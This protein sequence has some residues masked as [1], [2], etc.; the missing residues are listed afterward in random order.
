MKRLILIFVALLPYF[1]VAQSQS[2]KIVEKA[3]TIKTLSCDFEQSRT[4]TMLEQAV[5]SS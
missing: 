2:Q 3:A 1:A 4:S 5:N